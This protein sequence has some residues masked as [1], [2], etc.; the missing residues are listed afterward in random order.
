MEEL[1][2]KAPACGDDNGSIVIS[3]NG[4]SGTILYSIDNGVTFQNSGIFK[5]LAVGDYAIVVTN[6]EGFCTINGGSASIKEPTGCDT[7]NAN[8]IE[9]TT[10]D[11][12][13]CDAEDGTIA[14]TDNVA[15]TVEYSIDGGATFV[16]LK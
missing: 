2:S 3:I 6:E 12:T 7:C 13:T 4:I 11:A 9:V 10:T 14:I 16:Q 8:A 15:G 1:L 5:N